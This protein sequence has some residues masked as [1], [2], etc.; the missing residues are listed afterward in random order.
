MENPGTLSDDELVSHLER[1]VEDERQRLHVFIAW[2]G[3]LDL[4]KKKI[5]EMGYFSTFDFCVRHLKLSEDES[6]RRIRAARA[7]VARP[8]L[9]EAVAKGRLNLTAVSRLAP[10][11]RR[12]DAP[13]IIALAEGRTSRE[14]EELLAPLSTEPPR[15]DIMRVVSVPAP[16]TDPGA[17]PELRV[18]FSFRGSMDL[19]QAIDRL[20]ELLSHR[21]PGGGIDEVLLVIAKEY[22][23]RHDP[24]RGLPGRLSPVKGASSIAAGVR[25]AVWARDGGR[26]AYVGTTGARCLARRFLELDH[27]LPRALG[28]AD[29]VGNLRLLCRPH[30]DSE[31]RRIL[32]EGGG[33]AWATSGERRESS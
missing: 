2:L 25:R 12:E 4:R 33:A 9:L 1:F 24:Q 14:L 27:V 20:R 11:V 23:E 5:E 32:G 18:D 13:R 29:T 31:R 17:P 22:L 6:F 8:E 10:H 26:C 21:C 7:A 30:N 28:G 19:S 3:E 15:R 16:E